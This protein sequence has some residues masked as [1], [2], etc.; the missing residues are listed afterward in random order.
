MRRFEKVLGNYVYGRIHR[1][2]AERI[3][4]ELKLPEEELG[5]FIDGSVGPDSWGNFPHEKG[6]DR[7]ILSKI[8]AAR[9]LFLLNDIYCYGELG[10]ALH[11]LQDKWT[12]QITAVDKIELI[13]DDTLFPQTIIET[14]MPKKTV[15]EYLRIA[16][17]LALIK[18]RGIES[19]FEHDWG[20]WQVDYPSCIYLFADILELM[21][22]T[23]C[24]EVAQ[25]K[26]ME[27]WGKYVESPAFSKA[28]K[29]GFF[30][31][32]KTNF[33]IPK[34]SGYP[35]A[36]FC[37]VTTEPP[38][39]GRNANID[40]NIAYRL[41]REIAK[42]TLKPAKLLKYDDAWNQKNLHT[43]N[44]QYRLT[45]VTS[46]YHILIKR[47]VK[48]VQ[49]ER[50]KEFNQEEK[51]FLQTWPI[52]KDDLPNLKTRSETWKILLKGLVE[53]IKEKV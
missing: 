50:A 19:V 1:T 22:P 25:T 36:V 13:E 49:D 34:L 41:S 14:N 26:N 5:I 24:P 20:V 21:M 35:A 3:G 42:I 11:Y 8:D 12:H 29:D 46:Q 45:S 39:R 27:N 4:A 53:L 51:N 2:L 47:P 17:F 23:I 33:L 28:V 32:V 44:H 18:S 48:E 40:L 38:Y 37:L 15:E 31:S 52:I 43:N 16:D 10:N 30:Y 9:N 7:S 6:K